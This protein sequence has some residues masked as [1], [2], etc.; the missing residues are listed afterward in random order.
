MG[1]IETRKGLFAAFGSAF[2]C[3]DILEIAKENCSVLMPLYAVNKPYFT[4]LQNGPPTLQNCFDDAVQLPPGYK[5]EQ[6][7]FFA[8]IEKVS[9]RPAAVIDLLLGYPDEECCWVGLV[10][11]HGEMQNAGF[12]TKIASG[13]FAAAQAAGFEVVQLG[14][15]AGNEGAMRFWQRFGFAKVR[16]GALQTGPCLHDVIVLEKKLL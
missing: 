7:L 4:L 9:G 6:K 11:V 12:G 10:L 8:L 13:I 15:L 1:V 3:F 2:L 16:V 5:S 14:V